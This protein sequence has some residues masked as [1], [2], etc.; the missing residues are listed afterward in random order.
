MLKSFNGHKGLQPMLSWTKN[1]LR[2]LGKKNGKVQVKMRV[3]IRIQISRE[4]LKK[5]LDQ[6]IKLIN[7]CIRTVERITMVNV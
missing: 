3:G 1:R 4:R 5:I 6:A 7:C 2:I